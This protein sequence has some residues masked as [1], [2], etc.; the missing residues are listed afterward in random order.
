LPPDAHEAQA[1]RFAGT[2]VYQELAHAS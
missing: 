1:R 2:Y